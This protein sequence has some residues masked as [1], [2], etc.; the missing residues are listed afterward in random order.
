MH[1]NYWITIRLDSLIGELCPIMLDFIIQSINFMKGLFSF[2]RMNS[3][4]TTRTLMNFST[5]KIKKYHAKLI[6][7]D[8]VSV[9]PMSLPTGT[10]YYMNVSC[11]FLRVTNF[12]K[13][14]LAAYDKELDDYLN[15]RY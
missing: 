14:E 2:R 10:L 15:D 9:Q 6:S 4:H 11:G 8:I 5:L 1:K 7:D 12:D 3:K 13:D